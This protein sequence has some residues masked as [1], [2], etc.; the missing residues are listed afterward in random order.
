MTTASTLTDLEE[1]TEKKLKQQMAFEDER[2]VIYDNSP[3]TDEL[4][5]ADECDCMTFTYCKHLSVFLSYNVWGDIDIS[6]RIKK[7][8][9][10]TG[11]LSNVW[12]EKHINATPTQH[13]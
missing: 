7:E 6:N 10:P 8:S 4:K 2:W 12:H 11:A 1:K 3:K 9:Q 13:V 5:V